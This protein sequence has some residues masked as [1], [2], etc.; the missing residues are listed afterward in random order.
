MT[1]TFMNWG[2][3][4]DLA[5]ALATIAGI[6][7]IVAAG[8]GFKQ[9]LVDTGIG[10]IVAERVADDTGKWLPSNPQ[11][12][13]EFIEEHGWKVQHYVIEE[14]DAPVVTGEMFDM[15]PAERVRCATCNRVIRHRD[16]DEPDD[17]HD[18]TGSYRCATRSNEYHA[19]A[20][21]TR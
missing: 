16:G 10:T 5:W 8:G 18:S 12:W 6:L 4:H 9:A 11:R 7:L 15:T 1:Q 21:V 14:H 17:W 19:P 13:P 2:M 3:S 20:G